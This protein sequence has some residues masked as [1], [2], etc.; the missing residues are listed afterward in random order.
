[1]FHYP[2]FVAP[3]HGSGRS[4]CASPKKMSKIRLL[5]PYMQA[6]EI[7]AARCWDWLNARPSFISMNIP[8]TH[9][10]SVRI[11][12]TTQCSN[13][14][15]AGRER[16]SACTPP[17]KCNRTWKASSVCWRNGSGRIVRSPIPLIDCENNMSPQK[18]DRRDCRTAVM[19]ARVSSQ[20]EAKEGFSIPAQDKLL[21]NHGSARNPDPLRNSS[22]ASKY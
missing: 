2:I 13:F 9:R 5:S 1:M 20:E 14:G 6:R 12:V 18:A 10:R 15:S 19:Y 4:G 17:A 7:R 11:L 3:S 22:T 8:P 21:R 16:K